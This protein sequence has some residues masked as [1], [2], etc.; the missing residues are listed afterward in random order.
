MHKALYLEPRRAG[1]LPVMAYGKAPPE[2]VIF[3]WKGR[4]FTSWIIQ[5]GR[6]IFHLGLWKRPKGLTDE[7]Y[8]FY[9]LEKHS[10]LKDTAFTAVKRDAKF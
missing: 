5:K 6:E 4:D 8:T 2:R 9:K 10:Y 3:L 7:F 1:V